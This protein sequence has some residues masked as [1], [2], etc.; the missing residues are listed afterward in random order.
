VRHDGQIEWWCRDCLTR[1][2]FDTAVHLAS[3]YGCSR[4]RAERPGDG[5]RFVAEDDSLRAICT[6][7]VSSDDRLLTV[8][9]D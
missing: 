6:R 3:V 7:C 2:L 4:C 1:D 5:W 9:D 8:G